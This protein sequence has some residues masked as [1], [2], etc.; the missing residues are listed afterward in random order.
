MFFLLGVT[1]AFNQ[2]N[3]FFSIFFFLKMIVLFAIMIEGRLVFPACSILLGLKPNITTYFSS[4]Q[5]WIPPGHYQG[6]LHVGCFIYACSSPVFL[7]AQL[8]TI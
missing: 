4:V 6:P 8:A 2:E 1:S 3:R 7:L 5:G